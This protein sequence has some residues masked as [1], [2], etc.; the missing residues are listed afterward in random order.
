MTPAQSPVI[1]PD[2]SWLDLWLPLAMLLLCISLYF[3]YL[4]KHAI[5]APLADDI[6]DVL[7]PVVE[8]VTAESPGA[9]FRSLYSQHN[10]HRT[11]ATRLVYMGALKITGEINFRTLTFLA[12]MALPLLLLALYQ[13]SAG[14]E[15]RLLLLIP[16]TLLL[17][18]LRAYGL[19]FWVMAAFAYFY[20]FLYGFYCLYFLHRISPARFVLA[21]LL[22][23][24]AS[25]TL[26]SGHITWLIGLASL[27]HQCLLR[28]N[29][30]WGYVV[31]WILATV[32]VLAAWQLGFDSRNSV[33]AMLTALLADP[34]HHLLYLLTLLGSATTESSVALSAATG[35]TLIV[36]LVA[37][38]VRDYHTGDI[39][40]HLC[41]WLVVFAAAAIVMGRGFTNVDYA[42][43]ARYAF[44]SVLMLASTWVLVA[45][46]CRLRSTL[47]LVVVSLAAATYCAAS[48]LN[49]S[50][51]LQP[52]MEKRVDNFN[53]GNYPAWPHSMLESNG[54]VARAIELN[55]Y[56]PP[57]RPIAEATVELRADSSKDQ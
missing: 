12:H 55:I 30:H 41:C 16:A 26:A 36:T 27:A 17:L 40:L 28:R 37:L 50:R 20:S 23:G 11:F 4:S 47:L 18:N 7:S 29:A 56:V 15:K 51:A 9:A 34:G 19:T 10:D 49:H 43:S 8:S 38:S 25:F 22:A 14:A 5:N 57:G 24:L 52:Y 35:A 13:M 45:V 6:F 48:W 21:V 42:L 2:R 53:K 1:S 33:A 46:R 44:P 3:G 39:R 31:A 54:V 32:S